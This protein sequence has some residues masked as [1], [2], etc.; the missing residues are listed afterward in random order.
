MSS[1]R[2]TLFLTAC[3]LALLVCPPAEAQMS[4][5][6]LFAP[7]EFNRFGIGGKANEGF[8]FTF[9]A[10]F[11]GLESPEVAKIGNPNVPE[12]EV[13][14]SEYHS[15]TQGNSADTS[16]LNWNFVPGQRYGFGYVHNRRGITGNIWRLNRQDQEYTFNDASV[17]F[18]DKVT[19]AGQLHLVGQYVV[20][21]PL[22]PLPTV[23]D[24]L[25]IRNR[26]ETWG[27]E[28]NY[29]LRS[30]QLHKGGYIE[31][32]AGVRYMEFNERFNLDGYQGILIIT[33]DDPDYEKY[34]AAS[35]D[36]ED[37]GT[38][39]EDDDEDIVILGNAGILDTTALQHNSNNHLIGPQIGVRMFR[40]QER[41]TLSAE[42]KFFAASNSQS[43]HQFGLIGSELDPPGDLGEPI[44]MGPTN[45][46]HNYNTTEFSPGAELRVDLQWQWTKA[47]SFRLSW[48]GLFIDNVARSA[49]MIDYTLYSNS[50]MGILRENNRQS[51]FM[52]GISGGIMFNY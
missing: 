9:D 27:G 7:A 47:V 18:D 3:I 39:A 46:V 2:L 26:V 41:F 12:R 43:I 51:V 5:M 10:L 38:T 37:G 16:Q 4:D 42:G 17:N 44:A 32:T 50:A 11:W 45:F 14:V 52:N 49:D 48:T 29:L 24:T 21:G 20:G 35:G 30:H 13:W 33:P 6:Q 23:Y 19:G 25:S 28:V 40:R 8:Y 22:L 34:K 1:K 31:L 15:T 36:S